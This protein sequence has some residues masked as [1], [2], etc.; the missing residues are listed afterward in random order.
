M[1]IKTRHLALIFIVFI[2]L[3]SSCKTPTSQSNLPSRIEI[4]GDDWPARIGF[5]TNRSVVISVYDGYDTGFTAVEPPIRQYTLNLL[6][7]DGGA[8]GILIGSRLIWWGEYWDYTTQQMP[9]ALRESVTSI[10]E[11]SNKRFDPGQT[12]K[13]P[14]PPSYYAAFIDDQNV[15]N[16]EAAWKDYGKEDSRFIVTRF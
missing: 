6:V 8:V 13:P 9:K 16:L 3:L 2:G 7:C 4:L 10:I 12:I 11:I 5:T 1:Q 14:I 15:T